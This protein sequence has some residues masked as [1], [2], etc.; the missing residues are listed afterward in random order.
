M[1]VAQVEEFRRIKCTRHRHHLPRPARHRAQHVHARAVRHRRHVDLAAMRVQRLD[2]G[3]VRHRHR[4]QIA[5]RQHRALRSAGGAAG[6]EQPRDRLRIDGRGRQRLA[7]QHRLVIRLTD[8]H[9]APSVRRGGMRQVGQQLRRGEHQRDLGVF[10]DLQHFLVVQLEVDRHDGRFG[11][12]GG[13]DQLDVFAAVFADQRDA[14]TGLAALADARRQTQRA[15]AQLAP[16]Q[17]LLQA[18]EHGP[19]VGVAQG[20][21]VEQ[22]KKIHL[23]ASLARCSADPRPDDDGALVS[24]CAPGSDLRQTMTTSPITATLCV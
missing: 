15:G 24:H 5:V 7:R 13:E 22:G 20:G 19:V 6:V 11:G 1:L 14:V 23:G 16:G 21:L 10:E 12:P 4:Q 18:L 9:H 17:H 2:V 8:H 3:Q